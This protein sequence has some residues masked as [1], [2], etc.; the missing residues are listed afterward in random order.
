MIARGKVKAEPETLGA[1]NVAG[2]PVQLLNGRFGPYWQ[3][4]EGKDA[5]RASIP[6]WVIDAEKQHDLEIANRYLSLPR[7][8]GKDKDGNDIVAAK[9]KFGPFISCNGEF[10]NLRKTDHDAQL[11]SI[12]LEEALAL[13]AEEKPKAGAKGKG[14]GRASSAVVRQIGE[15]EKEP[16]ALATGRY[17]YYLKVGKDNIALPPKYKHDDELAKAISLEDAAEIIRTKRAKDSEE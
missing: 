17:G 1:G 15:F 8:L 12:T 2:L 13:L 5:K 6:K 9:G 4:G 14:K 16:V 11:F 7:L 10:R 3:E